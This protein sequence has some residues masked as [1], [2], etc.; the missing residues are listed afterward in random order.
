MA[1]TA[2]P[3]RDTTA[4]IPTATLDEILLGTAEDRPNEGG[5][6]TLPDGWQHA[7]VVRRLNDA[8]PARRE[9]MMAMGFGLLAL[10]WA[11]MGI[12][13][14]IAGTENVF[15]GLSVLLA[16]LVLA[17]R[18]TSVAATLGQVADGIRPAFHRAAAGAR[19]LTERA[20]TDAGPVTER[21]GA[22]ARRAGTRLRREVGPAL[23][24][25]RAA[26]VHAGTRARVRAKDLMT[27]FREAGERGGQVSPSSQSSGLSDPLSRWLDGQSTPSSTR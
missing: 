10:V 19:D 15:I 21:I 18:P 5:L 23:A 7:A 27:T 20:R 16:V 22:A 14:V 1:T 11:P 8:P 3:E 12:M 17:P 24:S 4:T 26:I 9:G 25:A 2:T 6:P 13:A